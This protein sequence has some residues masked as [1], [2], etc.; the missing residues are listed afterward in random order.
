MSATTEPGAGA[1]IDHDHFALFGLPH[2]FQQD[3]GA[4]DQAWRELQAK[5]HP[6][7][8]AAGSPGE[9]RIA[10]QWASR[11]NE[12]HRVL[13][14]PLLRARYLCELAG[15]PVQAENNTAMAPA[16]LMQQLEWREAIEAARKSAD[17]AAFGS[18][19]SELDEARRS[20]V[21]TVAQALDGEPR[22]LP[23][24]VARV[25]EWMFLERLLE[26]IDAHRP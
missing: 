13:R 21:A 11:V 16:F 26:E 8:Y 15:H 24:A 3:R 12:A 19:E 4:I 6:D 7:R 14:S 5:V 22:D 1:R 2:G 23:T 10:M 20:M 18:I 25:R 17:A 9:R